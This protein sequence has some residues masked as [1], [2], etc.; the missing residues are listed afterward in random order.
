M[1]LSQRKVNLRFE[2]STSNVNCTLLA[3]ADTIDHYETSDGNS[4]SDYSV[5]SSHMVGGNF[6]NNGLVDDVVWGET[7]EAF[8]DFQNDDYEDN[9][10]S[11]FGDDLSDGGFDFEF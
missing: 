4:S 2:R 10:D 1:K 3:E 9:D 5:D 8:I 7:V 6:E 11:S